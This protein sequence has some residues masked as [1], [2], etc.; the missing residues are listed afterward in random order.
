[1]ILFV[2]CTLF[3]GG[4]KKEY[5]KEKDKIYLKSW[6]E[7]LGIMKIEV[8][9]ADPES[10]K[11][12]YFNCK[13]DLVFGKDKN[14]LY[15]DG[16]E[17]KKA[18]QNTFNLVG[19]FVFRDKDSAYFLGFYDEI[20]N[21]TI[22]NVNPNTIKVFSIFLWAKTNKSIIWGKET[23]NVNNVSKFVP[24]NENWG[25]TDSQIIFQNNIVE[26]VDYYSFKVIDNYKGKDK[27]NT[28]ENGKIVSNQFNYNF[29]N[30]T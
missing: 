17:F 30:Y 25:K 23:F 24:I 18:D 7:G 16:I 11:T 19:N 29:R 15:I 2:F 3:L 8:I 27:N 13:S 20:E 6:N 28:F 12:I 4:C 10:F 26:D 22:H 1:M 5:I 21:T 9:N 14:C